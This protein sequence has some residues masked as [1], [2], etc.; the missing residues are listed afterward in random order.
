MNKELKKV[1]KPTK[2]TLRKQE[3]EAILDEL[4]SA[5]KKIVN[6]KWYISLPEACKIIGESYE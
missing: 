4:W 2:E 6:G 5:E 3:R 1:V